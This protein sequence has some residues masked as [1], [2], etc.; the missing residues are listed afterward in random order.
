MD[1]GAGTDY[2]AGGTG[3]DTFVF[4][5][6]DAF[7]LGDPASQRDLPL[8]FDRDTIL[9]FNRAEGDRI[10][11]DGLLLALTEFSGGTPQ[12]AM[13]QGYLYVVEHAGSIGGPLSTA[14]FDRDGGEHA[15][16]GGGD[17]AVA[18]VHATA[19]QLTADA[20]QTNSFVGGNL[21]L[22]ALAVQAQ[23]LTAF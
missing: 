12:Q 22:H 3:A 14:Y 8:G 19:D 5:A 7:P 13:D 11:L 6:Q 17:I 10:D 18:L 15:G 2:L 20:F 1:G 4:S 23:Y 21:H 9:D 16:P